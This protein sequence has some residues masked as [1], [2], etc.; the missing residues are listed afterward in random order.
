MEKVRYGTLT[1]F[2]TFLGSIVVYRPY[3]LADNKFLDDF[4]SSE[5]V[6]VLVLILTITFASVANIHLTL[7]RISSLVDD[8]AAIGKI[9]KRINRSASLILWSFIFAILMLI[10]KGWSLGNV[11]LVAL[12]H[13]ACLLILLLNVLILHT[14]YRSVFWL[15]KVNIPDK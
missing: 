3:W 7:T 10:V 8:S 2:A 13:G 1:F 6:A 12:S 5:I 11:Y 4:I 14:I 9:R 15:S